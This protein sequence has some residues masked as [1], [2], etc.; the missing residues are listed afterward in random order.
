MAQQASRTA[1]RA[2]RP[3]WRRL[4]PSD[5]GARARREAARLAYRDV[6][7]QAR[8]PA[9]FSELG[10]P[11]TPEGRFEMIALHA[12]LVLRRLRAEGEPGRALGQELFDLMLADFD[13]N[14]REL[15]VGDLSVGRYVKRLARNFYARVT[16]LDAGLATDDPD[17][18]LPM[19]R[20]NV[21]HGGPAPTAAQVEVLAAYFAAQ[22]AALGG[23]T[24][25]ALLAGRVRFTPP[26]LR[27]AARPPM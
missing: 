9:L 20:T 5:P 19:L 6:V 21:Y 3:W 15:G 27:A 26:A 8:T 22:A 16:A 7:E 25:D 2:R 17:A 13:V 18:L 14:L 24:G 12:A 1:A 10:V 11:D 4:W 23:Q